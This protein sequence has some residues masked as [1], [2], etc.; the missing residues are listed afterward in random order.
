MTWTFVMLLFAIPLSQ[1]TIEISRRQVPQVFDVFHGLRG[2]WAVAS[3]RDFPKQFEQ[4]LEKASIL[5]SFVQPRLQ[6]VLTERLHVGNNRAIVGRGGWLFYQPGVDF[7]AGPDVTDASFL[8]LAAKKRI[9]KEGDRDP[10][11]DPRPAILA[12]NRDCAAAGIRLVVVPVPDKAMLQPGQ[13]TGRMAHDRPVTPPNNRGYDRLIADLRQQGVDVFDPTPA[14][15][16][17][18]DVRYLVQDTHWTPEFMDTVAAGFARHIGPPFEA[19]TT[20]GAR[21]S[22]RAVPASRLGDIVDLL[23]IPE[24]QRIYRAQSVVVQQVID[25]R[26]GAPWEPDP[27]ADVLLLGD[28]FTNIYSQPAMGWGA[29]GGFAEHLSYH[30]GR[31]VDVIALNGAGASTV[32]EELSRR[33]ATRAGP[34]PSKVIVYEFAMRF[35]MGENWR[36]IP[37]KPS[38]ARAA[39]VVPVATAQP[40]TPARRSEPGAS[41][42]VS[43]I[44]TVVQTSKVPAPGT[45]PY[46][47]CLTYVRLRIERVDAGSRP[48]TEVIGAF[49]AMKEDVW[50]PAATYAVGD[51]LRLTMIPMERAE[52]RIQALQRADDLNNF[53]LKVFFVTRE[54]PQ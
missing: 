2:G 52:R 40:D 42:P 25:R 4:A 53:T 54:V 17:P 37:F 35:L 21:F 48:G 26:T 41:A 3:S 39:V 38:T 20:A 32:R 13:L 28:S 36:P 1:A 49:W 15:I 51:R 27:A 18:G 45:A 12:L 11:P 22:L 9:D 31:S 47:D 5:K 6:A 16:G 30:L 7:V 46:K 10:A 19:A 23:K 33:A 24:T 44:A 50:L 29:S 43:V 34:W 14:A 8:A